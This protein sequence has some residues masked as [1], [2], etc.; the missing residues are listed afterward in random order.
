MPHHTLFLRGSI[1]TDSLEVVARTVFGALG[2]EVWEERLSSNYP[3]D[4]HYF[5]GYT[6][7]VELTVYD[8]DSSTKSGYPF[9][10]ALEEATWRKGPKQIAADP[11]QIAETL[12][13][14]GISV[15]VPAGAWYKTDWDGK[16]DLYAA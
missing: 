16:G 9:H 2:V 1:P 4:D 3:P 13:R 11:K 12:A 7:N 6:E 14:V 15:F 10:L 8:D 5:A